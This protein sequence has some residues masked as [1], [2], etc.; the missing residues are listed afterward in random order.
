MELHAHSSN[1]VKV[2][3]DSN[4]M[5]VKEGNLFNYIED[6]QTNDRYYF[7]KDSEWS[8]GGTIS[9]GE[10]FFIYKLNLPKQCYSSEFE[11][12]HTWGVSFIFKEPIHT[13]DEKV[14]FDS[15][16]NMESDDLVNYLDGIGK[17]APLMVINSNSNRC[18]EIMIKLGSG[19]CPKRSAMQNMFA[20][21][22]EGSGLT[23]LETIPFKNDDGKGGKYIEELPFGEMLFPYPIF[24][25]VDDDNGLY[26]QI[27]GE[28]IDYIVMLTESERN[29]LQ[30]YVDPYPDGNDPINFG[31][32]ISVIPKF[33]NK[34]YCLYILGSDI[35]W[36]RP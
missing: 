10:L 36:K 30:V 22:I 16:I 4:Y 15:L 23:L 20:N 11:D 29:L 18:I 8:R 27:K 28:L 9:E 14:R 12:W 24:S 3:Y 32:A 25:Y 6:S 34:L 7:H 21:K 1:C 2:I 19:M 33:C 5:V 13:D 31:A 35:N 26:P 17:A